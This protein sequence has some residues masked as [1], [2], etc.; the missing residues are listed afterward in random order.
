[1]RHRF[2]GA[3][4]RI[5]LIE[6]EENVQIDFF[7]E[8]PS[9]PHDRLDS[10]FDLGVSS[11][12]AQR[13]MELGLFAARIHVAAMKG[14][15]QLRIGRMAHPSLLTC[16]KYEVISNFSVLPEKSRTLQLE[17]LPTSPNSRIDELL[18]HR[19]RA[20]T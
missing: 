16:Q 18:P 17:R 5:S 7:N 13:N 6:T 20:A 9:I 8:G 1:M 3:E 11:E 12:E 14:L 15:F 10:I 4:I 19:W 2:P